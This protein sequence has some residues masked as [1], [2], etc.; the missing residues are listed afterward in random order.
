MPQSFYE[1]RAS[2]EKRDGMHFIAECGIERSALPLATNVD[3]RGLVPVISTLLVPT[4]SLRHI[5]SD[6][7]KTSGTRH[8]P[9]PDVLKKV[10][11][12]APR[13]SVKDDKSVRNKRRKEGRRLQ[14]FYR[15][16]QGLGRPYF[17][18]HVD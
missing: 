8:L 5:N 10:C 17:W 12:F 15:S 18:Q 6:V 3:G 9:V 14:A 7:A 13:K 1:R 2:S 4:L 16:S 11:T